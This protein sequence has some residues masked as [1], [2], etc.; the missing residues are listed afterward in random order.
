MKKIRSIGGSRNFERRGGGVRPLKAF[1]LIFGLESREEL[2][3]INGIWG[4]NLQ[5]K[6]GKQPRN[7]PRHPRMLD[8]DTRAHCTARW[9]NYE[10]RG[11]TSFYSI[12]NIHYHVMS[13]VVCLL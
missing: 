4:S 7:H 11:L 1:L 10:L 5:V 2:Q 9:V 3:L 12:E 13:D 8:V 6:G